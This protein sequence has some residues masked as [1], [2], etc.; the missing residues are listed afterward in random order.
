MKNVLPK[1][2]FKN[3]FPA[4]R[5]YIFKKQMYVKEAITMTDSRQILY[6]I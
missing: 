4:L 5:V 2:L 1:H 6:L 3:S